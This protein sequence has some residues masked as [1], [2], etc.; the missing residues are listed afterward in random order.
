MRVTRHPK[1]DLRAAAADNADH[2]ANHPRPTDVI[3]F[4][5]HHDNEALKGSAAVGLL[6]GV[7]PVRR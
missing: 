1:R 5:H 4:I 2:T 6:F 7:T 3:R